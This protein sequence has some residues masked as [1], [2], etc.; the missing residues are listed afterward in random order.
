[1]VWIG[2]WEVLGGGMGIMG[3]TYGALNP[4]SDPQADGRGGITA[5]WMFPGDTPVLVKFS[6]CRIVSWSKVE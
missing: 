3:Y 1:M 6:G 2:Y 5:W 4:K